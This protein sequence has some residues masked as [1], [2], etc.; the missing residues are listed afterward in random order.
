MSQTSTRNRRT[1][2]L[3]LAVG[4]VA[5]GWSAIFVRWTHMPGIASAFYRVLFAAIALWPFLLARRER[6]QVTRRVV[7]ATLL[8]GVFF[9]GDIGLYNIAVN[10]TSAA[11]ATFLG[12]NAPV[13]VGLITWALTRRRPALRFW[14]A[15]GIALLGAILIV[16]VDH[17]RLA[18]AS[19]ADGLA[20]IASF[21]FALF[22]V[23]TERVRG[24]CDSAVLVALSASASAATLLVVA[25]LGHVSLAV[26]GWPQF[27]ALL[28]MAFICQIAGYFALTYALGHLPATTTSVTML[29][30]APLTAV[31]ALLIFGERQSALQILG[32]AFILAGIWLANRTPALHEPAPAME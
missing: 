5:I 28:G 11:N 3:A 25:L 1:A 20:V 14:T 24:A 27:A 19:A 2:T 30:V 16:A 8:G 9:A 13:F 31:F 26:P 17:Q 22:L 29:G 6:A 23:V 12:N 7:F 4:V 21:N 10:H 15:L 32:D 18:S